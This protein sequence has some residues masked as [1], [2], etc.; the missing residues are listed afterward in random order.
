M[1]Y[2]SRSRSG[3][4]VFLPLGLP[5]CL[6]NASIHAALMI[7]IVLLEIAPDEQDLPV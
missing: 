6:A 4:R 5:V 7:W 1:D 2:R 3:N